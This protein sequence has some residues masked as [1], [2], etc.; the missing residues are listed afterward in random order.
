LQ[1]EKG[2]ELN[3]GVI[4]SDDEFVREAFD[5]RGIPQSIFVKDGVAYYMNWAQMGINRILEFIERYEAI[6]EDATHTLQPAPNR[7]TIYKHY[8]LRWIGSRGTRHF[9]L[10]MNSWV[11]TVWQVVDPSLKLW[12]S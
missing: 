11:Q 2:K 6:T 1:R 9:Y 7:L 5:F 12:P 10:A 3:V 8:Y 4:Y